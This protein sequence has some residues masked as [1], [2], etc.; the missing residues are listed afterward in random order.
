MVINK[1]IIIA[2]GRTQKNQPPNVENHCHTHNPYNKNN[3]L[4]EKYGKA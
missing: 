3:E 2:I 4:V 1:T